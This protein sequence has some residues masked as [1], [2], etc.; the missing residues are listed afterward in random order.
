[1][2]KPNTHYGELKD[3][4]LFYN[5]AQKTKAYVEQYPG[6]KLLRMDAD[7]TISKDSYQSILET[8]KGDFSGPEWVSVVIAILFV[9]IIVLMIVALI[10][11]SF[12]V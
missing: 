4:Y 11:F 5:I 7:S 12:L 8:Y 3:S 6:V 10:Y 1:M 2:I 9:F